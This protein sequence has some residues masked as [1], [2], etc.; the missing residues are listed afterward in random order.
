MSKSNTIKALPAVPSENW[1][2]AADADIDV[3]RG[4]GTQ[5]PLFLVHD[6]H[7]QTDYGAALARHIDIDMPVYGLPGAALHEEL[8]CTIESLARR[9]VVL[10]RT[11]QP[12]SP[13]RVAGVAFGGVLSYEIAVQLIGEDQDVEFLGLIDSVCPRLL[14]EAP[15]TRLPSIEDQLL[16]CCVENYDASDAASAIALVSLQSTAGLDFDALLRRCRAE[17]ILPEYLHSKDAAHVRHHLARLAAHRYAQQH[18]AVQNLPI[19]VHLFSG[20]K[21]SQS[22]TLEP[23]DPLKGWSAILP[24]DQLRSIRVSGPAVSMLPPPHAAALARH[25]PRSPLRYM[26]ACG[27]TWYGSFTKRSAVNSGWFRYPPMT[28]VGARRDDRPGGRRFSSSPKQS[29]G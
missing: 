26:R 6:I 17:H 29:T 8:P 3:F 5:P 23:A 16:N 24:H 10:M 9:C 2:P 4:T 15:M 21:H 18:Y 22:P 14:R 11:V 25:L 27:S 20:T 12:D 13:Y 28:V 7:G 1:Y 19:P